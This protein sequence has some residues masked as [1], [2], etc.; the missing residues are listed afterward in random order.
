MKLQNSTVG[1]RDPR[2]TWYRNQGANWEEGGNENRDVS[3]IQ[4][5]RKRSLD[6]SLK[7]LGAYSSHLYFRLTTLL[8]KLNWRL[9]RQLKICGKIQT[10]DIG[11]LYYGC[12]AEKRQGMKV[13]RGY[14][15]DELY[16]FLQ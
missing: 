15:G 1:V 6:F 5:V 4:T 7:E 9:G 10:R 8:K 2:V 13:F 14:P 16:P 12:G 3:R 11:C